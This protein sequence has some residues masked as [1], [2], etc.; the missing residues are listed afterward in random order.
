MANGRHTQYHLE[1]HCYIASVVAGLLQL[2]LYIIIKYITYNFSPREMI[3]TYVGVFGAGIG[4]HCVVNVRRSAA[5]STA[6]V[7]EGTESYRSKWVGG[8]SGH[9]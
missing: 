5:G 1:E 9:P 2:M 8:A 3:L 6:G 4:G 7:R